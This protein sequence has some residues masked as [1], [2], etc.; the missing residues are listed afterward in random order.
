MF[1]DFLGF[2]SCTIQYIVSFISQRGPGELIFNVTDLIT[3]FKKLAVYNYVVAF[4]LL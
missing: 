4:C 2:I 1:L 3:K